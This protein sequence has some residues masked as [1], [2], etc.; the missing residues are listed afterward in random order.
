MQMGSSTR[1]LV[2]EKR[3]LVAVARYVPN[4]QILS[5]RFRSELIIPP[6]KSQLCKRQANEQPGIRSRI[7]GVKGM[8][9]HQII[10]RQV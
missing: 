5:I 1:N 6:R 10:P 3:V 4:L 9:I 8:K 2:K 7:V